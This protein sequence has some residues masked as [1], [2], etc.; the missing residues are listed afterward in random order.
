LTLFEKRCDP[1][2]FSARRSSLLEFIASPRFHS[3]TPADNAMEQTACLSKAAGSLRSLAA[4][5][6]FVPHSLL[7]V[8]LHP[9][10]P[11]RKRSIS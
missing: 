8:R 1:A 6:C 7:D 11:S 4:F 9:S 2:I 3:Q 5:T 10:F